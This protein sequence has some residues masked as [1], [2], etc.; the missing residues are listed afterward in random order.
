MTYAKR[1]REL[2]SPQIPAESPEQVF[3][4][5]SWLELSPRYTCGDDGG[6][7]NIWITWAENG[8]GEF[9]KMKI[10]AWS[11]EEV[12]MD[13]GGKKARCQHNWQIQ[14]AVTCVFFSIMHLLYFY[15]TYFAC[16]RCA[17]HWGRHFMHLIWSL[18]HF[19]EVER[20][21]P[22]LNEEDTKSQGSY[23]T[24]SRLYT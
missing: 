2:L 19:Y 10:G 12:G 11:I 13:A 5:S 16:T 17:R 23:I 7:S 15:A 14:H 24:N 9:P 18:M 22:Y 6:N 21:D 4:T 8:M 3:T 1:G 20:H